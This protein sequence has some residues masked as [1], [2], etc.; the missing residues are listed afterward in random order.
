MTEFSNEGDVTAGLTKAERAT[1]QQNRK[2]IDK[3][4]K[5]FDG[6][7][8]QEFIIS[9]DFEAFLITKSI[10]DLQTATKWLEKARTLTKPR[11]DRDTILID[12]LV[13]LQNQNDSQL[14]EYDSTLGEFNEF[15][16][17]FPDTRFKTVT[18]VAKIQED[19]RAVVGEQIF[20][21]DQSFYMQT[22]LGIL[23]RKVILDLSNETLERE[24]E[25]WAGPLSVYINRRT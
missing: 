16:E 8:N 11:R 6:A 17:T 21:R 18:E 3:L 22:F 1:I 10:D 23:Q 14:A 15:L 4:P 9:R 25:S 19:L 7:Q 20:K 13:G 5:Y 2:E 12:T 24:L